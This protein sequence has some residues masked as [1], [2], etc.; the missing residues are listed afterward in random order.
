MSN[1]MLGKTVLIRDH[2]AGVLFG[3]LSQQE[4]KMWVLQ[5][6]RKIHYWAK[7]AAVEGIVAKG[8]VGQGSRVTPSVELMQGF[9]AVQV[10]LL[11]DA[12][13]KELMDYAVWEP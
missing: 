7:A 5:N 8:A 12:Q 9:D 4:G 11:P 1:P 13:Y 10:I 3:T 6:A 2:M